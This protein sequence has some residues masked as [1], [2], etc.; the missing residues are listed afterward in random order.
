[1]LERETDPAKSP[2]P[3]DGADYLI[4]KAPV[5]KLLARLHRMT[6]G[7]LDDPDLELIEFYKSVLIGR[8][9]DA[10]IKALDRLT[11]TL[12]SASKKSTFLGWGLIAVSLGTWALLCLEIYKILF[13]K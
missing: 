10:Q 13:M 3:N 9:T 12:N 8:Y 2:T 11:T 4:N 1:M 6:Q 5:D 7:P